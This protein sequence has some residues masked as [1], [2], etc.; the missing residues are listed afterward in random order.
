MSTQ[1]QETEYAAPGCAC[2]S[3]PGR[4][5]LRHLI[6]VLSQMNGWTACPEDIKPQPENDRH[7][8]RQV[9]ELADF[10]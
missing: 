9:P 3:D 1:K 5:R 6:D 2:R 7:W 4:Y 8:V 10:A